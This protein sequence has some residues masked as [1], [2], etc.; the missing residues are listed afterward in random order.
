MGCSCGRFR[1][2]DLKE[3]SIAANSMGFIGYEPKGVFSARGFK[4]CV[5]RPCRQ[6]SPRKTV[7]SSREPA[8]RRPATFFER[9]KTQGLYACADTRRDRGE[10]VRS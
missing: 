2:S 6:G 7:L 8:A 4:H 5:G 10:A 1:Y 3:A 9:R